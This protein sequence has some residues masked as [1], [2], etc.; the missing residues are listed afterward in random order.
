M[1]L[2]LVFILLALVLIAACARDI[3]MGCEAPYIP[4]ENACCL[5]ANNDS[6]CDI[7]EDLD[8]NQTNTTQD[9]P[10][11]IPEPE[12]LPEEVNENLPR[13]Y[14]QDEKNELAIEFADLLQDIWEG[15]AWGL[16]YQHIPKA[17]QNISEKEFTFYAYINSDKIRAGYD[18]DY[19]YVYLWWHFDGMKGSQLLLLNLTVNGDEGSVHFNATYG[20]VFVEPKILPIVWQN[21]SW[22]VRTW[23][24]VY[25]GSTPESVC[26]GTN[27]SAYCY[28]EYAQEFRLLDYC[29]QSG[30]YVVDCYEGFS[31]VPTIDAALAACSR[32]VHLTPHDQCLNLAMLASGD[33]L[34]CEG[35]HLRP[36]YYHCLGIAAGHDEELDDC[37][38]A[39]NETGR[40]KD[41]YKAQCVYGYVEYTRNTRKCAETPKNELDMKDDCYKLK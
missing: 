32:Y 28:S 17:E 33:A 7:D 34:I 13:V 1:R 4:Y 2:Q 30:T 11:E 38:D 10:I 27:Y 14:T 21:D 29:S 23:N 19:E 18:P 35:I 22:N 15:E 20:D 16:L 31:K 24:V 3:V 6:I 40:A 26:D 25:R 8:L 39:I 9:I 37:F 36:N 41:H 12:E 5:D